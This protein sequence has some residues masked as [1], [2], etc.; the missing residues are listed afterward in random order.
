[1]TRP[2]NYGA[3]P[4]YL[5]S[6]LNTTIGNIKSTQEASFR[7]GYPIISIS[8]IEDMRLDTLTASITI[9][10][11]VQSAPFLPLTRRPTLYHRF[12]ASTCDFY[13]YVDGGKVF[14][15]YTIEMAGWGNDESASSCAAGVSGIIQTQCNTLLENFNLHTNP[16]KLTRHPDQ[17]SRSQD[18]RTSARLRGRGAEARELIRPSRAGH[19]MFLSC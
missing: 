6:M 18:S 19:P 5:H 8:Y 7:V 2:L 12:D 14:N 13:G 17:L 4:V 16:R 3:A 11:T 15:Q 10:R 9:F 1:M